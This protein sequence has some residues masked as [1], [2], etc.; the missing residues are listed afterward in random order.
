MPHLIAS[1]LVLIAACASPAPAP[2]PAAPPSTPPTSE[3]GAALA[4]AWTGQLEYRDFQSDERVVLPTW[5]T[6]TPAGA[7][8]QLD[9]VYDDGPAKTVR[10]RMMLTLDPAAQQIRFTSDRD[11]HDETYA[12]TGLAD[13]AR[14]HT[15]VLTGRGSESDHPVDVRITLTV[16]R[17]RY[18]L[19]KETRVPGAD[20]QFRD[21]YTFTRAAPR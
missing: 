11:H 9:Y 20:F 6:V 8:L 21:A 5:L 18:A 10:E 1:L 2:R 15:L 7:A 19:V 3:L 12:V 16:R 4:G 14:S 13:L 17:N